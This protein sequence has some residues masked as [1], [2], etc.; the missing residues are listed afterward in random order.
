MS[1]DRNYTVGYLGDVRKRSAYFLALL[2]NAAAKR[3]YER[4]RRDRTDADV[5]HDKP[6][7]HSG[8]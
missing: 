5:S 8:D 3:L 2:Q 4:H 7:A 6:A 1:N